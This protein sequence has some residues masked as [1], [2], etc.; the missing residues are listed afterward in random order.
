M[1]REL[2]LLILRILASVPINRRNEEV[3]AHIRSGV[4]AVCSGHA[5]AVLLVLLRLQEALHDLQFGRSAFPGL[6]EL[7]TQPDP[8]PNEEDIKRIFYQILNGQEP[9]L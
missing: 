7:I 9:T 4:E 6:A 5:P 3:T 2:R 8:H 1:N